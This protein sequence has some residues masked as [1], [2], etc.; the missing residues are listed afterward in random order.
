MVNQSR[1]IT[2]DSLHSL[3]D[4]LPDLPAAQKLH[5][6]YSEA[7]TGEGETLVDRFGE[8][9]LLQLPE[10]TRTS[11]LD[12]I[13]V[14]DKFE[15]QLLDAVT[16]AEVTDGVVDEYETLESVV[17]DSTQSHIEGTTPDARTL[18]EPWGLDQVATEAAS[19]HY[20]PI[21][22]PNWKAPSNKPFYFAKEPAFSLSQFDSQ[23]VPL[24]DIGL[25]GTF[26]VMQL[27]REF[28]KAVADSSISLQPAARLHALRAS[29]EPECNQTRSWKTRKVQ[30]PCRPKP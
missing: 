26:D 28:P 15:D 9:V 22:Y 16:V 27:A 2:F 19:L 10:W 23:E 7:I 30:S 20:S 24:V 21:S 14:Q 13:Q 18:V 1:A 8:E 3:R 12:A 25:Y 4:M 29:S 17:E 6:R 5:S 11:T